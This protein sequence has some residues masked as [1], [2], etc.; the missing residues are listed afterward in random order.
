MDVVTVVACLVLLLRY[1]RLSHS[2]PGTIYLFFHLYTF[3]FRLFGLLFGAE[4]LF[5]Q[6]QGFFE[7]ITHGEIVRAALLGDLA[8]AVMTIAWIKAAA[9]DLKKIRRSPELLVEGESNLSLRYIWIVVAIAFP[10]GIIGLLTFA[11]VPGLSVMRDALE[12]GE[13][14]TSSYFFIL[15]VWAGLALLALIY[16]YGFRWWLALPMSL[17]LLIMAY[18]GYH[19]FRV[20][21]PA[22][23]LVQIFLDRRKL[24]WPPLPLAAV[25][26]ASLLIFFPLK[27]IGQMAQEGE[28]VNEI[29]SMST[30]SVNEALVAK[31]PD[32]QFLDQFACAL[33]LVDDAEHYY[34]GA[35][36][37]PLVTL[38]IPHQWWPDKP[39]LADYL[40]DIS[41]PWRPMSQLGMI[42]TFL[43]ESYINFGYVGIIV[44]PILLAYI[45]G[46][47]YF[48]AYRSNYFTIARLAYLLIACNLIQVYRDGL[49][50]IVIFT[51]V[52]MMPLMILI[53][54]HYILPSRRKKQTLSA[55]AVPELPNSAMH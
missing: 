55:Y 21:I 1:G 26:V 19:R 27:S 39:G 45:L 48:R 32:Q 43:G 4:T 49:V 42:V 14:Q 8:L 25:L 23:L 38:P 11:N 35:T 7:V 33:A 37:L 2:H 6:Y 16:W 9:D 34:Y 52:N 3:T 31:A 50:S 30:E 24:R 29:V 51:W 28:S 13:W 22:L 18:Q 5:S 46:R 15:Q 36:Y 20:L 12:P 17:Y 40:K 41:K 54:L 53:L 10:L 47:V 44:I